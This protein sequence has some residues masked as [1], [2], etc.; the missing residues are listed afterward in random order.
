ME[1]YRWETFMDLIEVREWIFKKKEIL[2]IV[3]SG[4]TFLL[5]LII[6]INMRSE[7]EP[8]AVPASV[9]YLKKPIVKKDRSQSNNSPQDSEPPSSNSQQNPSS[10][11]G[12]FTQ[13]SPE[14]IL[15]RIQEYGEIEAMPDDY[16]I[17][18][19]P[20]G[21]GVYFF[22][23]GDKKENLINVYFDT[24]ETGFGAT[25]LSEVDIRLYPQFLEM[26]IGKKIWLAG[27]IEGVNPDGTGTFFVK[28]DVFS[29][30]GEPPV[31]PP[32]E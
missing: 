27:L 21:W 31:E 28:A 7:P 26:E 2:I 32:T 17:N 6:G 3:G 8:K 13:I 23:I 12:Y 1:V 11:K 4:V 20:I 25:V 9:V 18:N 29:F 5:M 15:N 16:Q 30:T 19:L 24:L 22:G 14:E 10:S